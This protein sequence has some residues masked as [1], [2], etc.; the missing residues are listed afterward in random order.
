MTAISFGHATT[1]A[2]GWIGQIGLAPVIASLVEQFSCE[3]APCDSGCV[4]VATDNSHCPH[5]IG[6]NKYFEATDGSVRNCGKQCD[7]CY[8]ENSLC[9][10]CAA[11]SLSLDLNDQCLCSDPQLF[12]DPVS[13]TCGDSKRILL[14]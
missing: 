11:P 5:S 2:R 1:S 4:L 9:L 6:R 13:Q 12:F 8:S 7:Q 3:G 14:D 10:E